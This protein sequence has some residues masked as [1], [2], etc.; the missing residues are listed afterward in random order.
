MYLWFITSLKLG[1]IVHIAELTVMRSFICQGPIQSWYPIEKRPGPAFDSGIVGI[2]MYQILLQ[3][4]AI[5]LACEM[6][7]T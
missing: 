3:I 4:W 1:K 5:D 7:V 6:G 2:E